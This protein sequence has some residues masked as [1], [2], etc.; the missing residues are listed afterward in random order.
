LE[1]TLE[2]AAG[3]LESFKWQFGVAPETGFVCLVESVYTFVMYDIIMH[4]VLKTI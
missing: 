3:D 1:H 4:S 2:S